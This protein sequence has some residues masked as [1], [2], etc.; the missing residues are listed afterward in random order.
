MLCKAARSGIAPVFFLS[1]LAL[2]LP[3]SALGQESSPLSDRQ[4]ADHIDELLRDELTRLWYPRTIVPEGG[5]HQNFARDWSML[6]D[7]DRFLVDQARLT[8]TAAAFADYDKEHRDTFLEYA[9][10]GIAYLDETMRDAEHGGFHWILNENG[11]VDPHSVTKNMRM[12]SASSSS[13]VPGFMRSAETSAPSRWPETPSTGSTHTPTT[14][15]TA[16][17]S[18]RSDETALR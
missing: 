6:P 15:S 16:A 10:H 1:F 4:L 5:F 9:R 11:E 7:H 14:T 3:G 18:K 12:R 13:R 8:W 17:I 2:A